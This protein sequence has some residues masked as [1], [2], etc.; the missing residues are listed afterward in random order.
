MLKIANVGT[1]DRIV[2][3]VAGTLLVA[4]P[5]IFPTLVF[6]N[7]VMRWGIPLIGIIL[8]GTAVLRVCPLYRL[9]GISTCKVD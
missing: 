7:P 6:E 1:L 2:R 5:Y 9:F 4:L 8:I 3:L